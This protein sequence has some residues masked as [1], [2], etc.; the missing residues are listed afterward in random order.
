M[1][2]F[3][4]LRSPEDLDTITRI[5]QCASP[6]KCARTIVEYAGDLPATR[7][8]EGLPGQLLGAAMQLATIEF[9]QVPCDH[10]GGDP[11]QNS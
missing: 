5:L 2:N 7:H 3:N 9:V 4:I 10:H 8:S 6:T 11:Y 1:T